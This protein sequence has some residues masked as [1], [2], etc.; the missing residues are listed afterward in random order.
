MKEQVEER[1]TFLETGKKTQKNIDAMKEVLDEL[2]TENLYFEDPSQMAKK[3]KKKK[4]KKVVEEEA[5][6][7]PLEVEAET[8]KKKKKVKTE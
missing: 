4:S 2:K 8:K 1:L 6:E 3:K 5:E 7:E